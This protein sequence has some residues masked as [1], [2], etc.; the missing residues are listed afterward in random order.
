MNCT[1]CGKLIIGRYYTNFWGENVHEGCQLI[2]C[3][4]CG[5][6]LPASHKKISDGRRICTVC[7]KTTVTDL[8]ELK[9]I[10]GK[11]RGML[12][13]VGLND[14]PPNTPVNIG[15]RQQLTQRFGSYSKGQS[16]LAQTVYKGLQQN[17]RITIV[18]YLPKV[19]CAGVLAH[20]LLHTWLNSHNI[21]MSPAR[22]EG[23]C[24]L[25]SYLV[26]SKIDHPMAKFNI[27]ALMNNPDPNYGE[28]FR[29]MLGQLKQIG[30]TDLIRRIKTYSNK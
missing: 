13:E 27:D 24:N 21:K 6:F 20:E 7:Q 8:T 14:I 19:S 28:G 18:S 23:F 4:S 5:R 2:T 30:W 15:N 26:Y 9:W 12:A 22:T 10:A 16:G 17:H 3:S 1:V 29:W 25:G 11:V